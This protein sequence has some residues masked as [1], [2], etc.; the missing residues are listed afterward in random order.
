MRGKWKG[1]ENGDLGACGGGLTEAQVARGGD[2]SRL[3]WAE[4]E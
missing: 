3:G 4:S 1:E 2:G